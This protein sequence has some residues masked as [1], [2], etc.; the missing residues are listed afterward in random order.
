MSSLNF[1]RIENIVDRRVCDIGFTVTALRDPYNARLRPVS[2]PSFR[3]FIDEVGHAN[4][5]SAEHP[6]ERY[7]SLTGV[8]MGVEYERT[9]FTNALNKLKADIFGTTEIVLHR[10]EIVYKR[11]PFEALRCDQLEARFD[12]AALSLIANCSYRVITIVIDKLEHKRRYL[13]WQAYPYHYC[14]MAMLERY[15]LWLKAAGVAGDVMAESRGKKENKMLSE[16]YSRLYEKGTDFVS[17]RTFQ[18]TLST[19][20]LKL[21]EKRANI[22][23]LQLADLIANPSMRSMICEKLGEEM[24]A[25]FGKKVVEILKRNKYRRRFDGQINGLGRKWLP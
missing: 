8:I 18:S 3:L 21:R 19:K 24:T 4:M 7:L 2:T 20:E 23:G 1:W 9:T 22:P 13:V 11:A 5:K 10:T 15:V 16:S 25:E 6:N 14:M 17:A 12:T